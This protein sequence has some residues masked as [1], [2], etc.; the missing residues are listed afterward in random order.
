MTV[1]CDRC[2]EP[3]ETELGISFRIMKDGSILCELC[4]E[5]IEDG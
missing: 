2:Q 3:C 4:G 1:I 5:D